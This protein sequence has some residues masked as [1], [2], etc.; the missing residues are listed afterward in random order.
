MPGCQ[1]LVAKDGNV[2]VDKS[3]GV[4]DKGS[5]A[6]QKVN[7][8]TIYDLASMSK[9]FG[10]LAALMKTYDDG[11]W[12]FDDKVG[13]FI[14]ET[15]NLP[16]G[17]LTMRQ[18]LYHKSGLPAGLNLFKLLLDT[19]TYSGDPIKYK[20]VAPYTI[21]IQ[22]GVYGHKD[23]KLRKD[24]F[25]TEK[26]D[27]F[28]LP[29]AEGIYA[30]PAARDTIMAAIYKLEPKAQKSY[31]YSDLNF[32]L[33]M[34]ILDNITGRPMDE[35]LEENVYVPL[36]MMHTFYTPYDDY[37]IAEIAPTETDNFMRKQHIRGYVHDE[38]AAFSG[39]LQGNAGLF[40]NVDDLSRL[41]QTWLNGGSYGGVQI[42]KPETVKLFTGSKA[43]DCDRFPGFDNL[44]SKKQ[45]GVSEKTYGHTGFTGTCFWIDPENGIVYIFLSN[46]VNPSR[47]NSA[48][49]KFNPRYN[50][51]K[52][53]Y[54]AIK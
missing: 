6:A 39:G 36:G 14:P 21:K 49:T 1:I 52:E 33:L 29:V 28:P 24:L 12:K 38:T 23:A 25:A 20:S 42:F 54:G 19:A 5:G 35:Y 27:S 11:L 45:W 46:R 34:K 31:L 48:F 47:D 40:S 32:C 4:V 37:P 50:V 53:V 16:V 7:C 26:S 44:V 9:A 51:L 30:S 41:C 8:N 2:I 13:K 15:K 43:P 10:T 3:Y 17:N 22:K 18:L